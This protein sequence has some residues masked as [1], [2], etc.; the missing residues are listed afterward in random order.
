[1]KKLIILMASVFMLLNV[2]GCSKKQEIVQ[3][4]ETEEIAKEKTEENIEGAKNFADPLPHILTDL[5]DASAKAPTL[6]ITGDKWTWSNEQ[7]QDIWSKQYPAMEVVFGPI[8]D[9]FWQQGLTWNMTDELLKTHVCEQY[10]E[11]NR[12]DVGDE[13]VANELN[14][15]GAQLVHETGHIWLQ[16]NNAGLTFECGQ[17][18]WEGNTLLFEELADIENHLPE[19]RDRYTPQNFFDL[20]NYMGGDIINGAVRDGDKCNRSFTD[21][22]AAQALVYLDS[23][24]STPG[25]YDYWQKVCIERTKYAQENNVTYTNPEILTKIMDKVADGKTFDGMGPGEWLFSRSV[26][27]TNGKDGIHLAV[28]GMYNGYVEDENGMV[29]SPF[30]Q[31]SESV[32]VY[33]IKRENGVEKGLEGTQVEVLFYDCDG[34]NISNETVT[35]DRDGEARDV[36]IHDRSGNEIVPENL[37]EYSATRYEA[38]AVINGKEYSDINFGLNTAPGDLITRTDNRMFFILINK[39]ETINTVLTDIEVSG[40]YN[41]FKN[42]LNHGLLIV[43]ANQG[44]NV[45]V[46]GKEYTKPIGSRIIPIVVG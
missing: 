23:A 9:D 34:F 2:V 30:G 10:A 28:Y 39:D 44:D 38:K 40:G 22:S 24:L 25:T 4:P 19:Y 31:R 43:Q 13:R 26:A 18:L 35:I 41:V 3:E 42:Y 36:L 6:Y 12:I 5:Q 16:N 14:R 7:L 32:N 27:N 17:W 15:A 45:V 29:V 20:Y 37:P 8:A 1:M 11:D 33:C 46:N 21:G